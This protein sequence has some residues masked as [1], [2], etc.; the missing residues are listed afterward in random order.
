[1]RIFWVN[2]RRALGVPRGYWRESVMFKKCVVFGAGLLV[3][4]VACAQDNALATKT[5][6]EIGVTLSDYKYSESGVSVKAAKLGID[7]TGT[8]AVSDGWFVQGELRYADGKAKYNGTGT[9]T[10]LPDWYYEIRGLVG[11]DFS[12]GD[13]TLSPY[14]GLG[15][16]YL[17]DDFRGTTS[18][19]AAGYRRESNYYTL[20][21]GVNHR[22]KLSN[23]AQV[24][25]TIEY[26]YL[27]RGRQETKLSDAVGYNGITALQD[28]SNPQHKGYGWRLSSMYQVDTWSI[29]PYLTLWHINDSDKVS[30]T[31]TVLGVTGTAQVWEPTNN[32]TEVGIKAS[33][34]F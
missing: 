22:T 7:Y 16:R 14:A 34:R 5:G 13:Y 8:Y 6:Q 33:Y 29:G 27:I 15:Y 1:M 26:D 30:V 24:L 4:G 20:P 32:T 2:I 3:A 12:F 28:A 19:G 23:N 11:K 9:K 25:T 17:F 31:G 10:G 18:T 21:I